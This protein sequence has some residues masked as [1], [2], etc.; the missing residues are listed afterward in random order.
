MDEIVE[1]CFV[2]LIALHLDAH[3]NFITLDTSMLN[4]LPKCTI[5]EDV[6]TYGV[7]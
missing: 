4:Q 2:F 5:G 3:Q 7:F 6:L 1:L